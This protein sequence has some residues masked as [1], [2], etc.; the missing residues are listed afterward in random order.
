MH[1]LHLI[2]LCS[3]NQRQQ[4][5]AQTDPKHRLGPIRTN[6]LP[7]VA[8]G[9]LAELRVSGTVTDEQ[10]VKVWRTEPRNDAFT[11]TLQENQPLLSSRLRGK[12]AESLT[13]HVQRVVPGN[14]GD[15]GSSAGQTADLVVLDAAVHRGDP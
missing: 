2:G 9:V 11:D 6:H 1:S 14:D 8:D 13:V 15:P 5:V 12:G 7:D 3:D 10:A 4:L